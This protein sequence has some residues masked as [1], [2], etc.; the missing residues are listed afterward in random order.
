MKKLHARELS[1]NQPILRFDV[2]L[3][4]DWP[5]EKCLLHIRVFLGGKTRRPRFDL[6]IHWLIKQITKTYQNHFS[7]SYEN[8]SRST[9]LEQV[10]PIH[11]IRTGAVSRVGLGNYT[12][13]YCGKR[14]IPFFYHSLQTPLSDICMGKK[15][16]L[17]VL[18]T[19]NETKICIYTPKRNDEHPHLSHTETLPVI[20]VKT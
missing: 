3:Q 6:F 10:A 19:L 17:S 20:R 4:H 11:L 16:L 9:E 8:R 18:N 12:P 7:R 14:A 1:R 2:I 15:Y 5:I 13:E